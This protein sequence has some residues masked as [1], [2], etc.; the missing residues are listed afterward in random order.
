MYRLIILLCLICSCKQGI[1]SAKQDIADSI[2]DKVPLS[3][4]QMAFH[5]NIDTTYKHNK[6][7]GASI[8][9]LGD[10]LYVARVNCSDD[11][12]MLVFNRFRLKGTDHMRIQSSDKFSHL[13]V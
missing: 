12:L 9:K 3:Y 2:R 10:S 1:L 5:F 8:D 13:N 4:E 6:F 7:S 11:Q